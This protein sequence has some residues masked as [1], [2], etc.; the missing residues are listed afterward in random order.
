[1]HSSKSGNTILGIRIT[2]MRYRW[3]VWGILVIT[4]VV[5][6]FHRMSVSVVREPLVEAFNLSATEFGAMASMYF[7]AYCLAQIPAGALADT[8]GARLTAGFSMLLAAIGTFVFAYATSPLGLYAGRFI[9]GLG[10]AAS[11]VCV[12]K[13]QS[14]WFKERE[15]STLAGACLL[16]GNLGSLFAQAPLVFLTAALSFSGAFTSIGMGTLI[17]A[18]LCFLLVR[19]TPQDVGLAS[20]KSAQPTTTTRALTLRQ[21]LKQALSDKRLYPLYLTYFFILPQ[22]FT[23]AGTWSAAYIQDIYQ[24]SLTDASNTA[25]LQVIGFMAGSLI[26]GIASDRCGRRRFFLVLPCLVLTLCLTA[27]VLPW[28]E[29]LPLYIFAVCLF[30]A[31]FCCGTLSIIMTLCKEYS[32]PETTGTAIAVLNTCGFFGIA[33]ATPFYGYILDT[34]TAYGFASPHQYALAFLT[35]LMAAA[36]LS[37]LFS[38]ETYGKNIS[39][40]K[41]ARQ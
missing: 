18:A 39:A 30:C 40:A 16:C 36:L 32:P 28:P 27:V 9:V 14:Q 31:G 6:F 23:F 12:M 8:V 10:V 15:F 22:F 4:Y 29:P 1:M 5:G 3:I 34:A 37:S 38:I 25:S 35:I 2:S 20:L 24:L 26:L 11:F 21:S 7:Y 17:L 19:N 41:P 13:I 33:L